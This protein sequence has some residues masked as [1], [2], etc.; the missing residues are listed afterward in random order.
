MALKAVLFGTGARLDA[1]TPTSRCGAAILVE[2]GGDRLVFDCG[3]RATKQLADAGYSIL[4]VDQIFFTHLHS[5][6]TVGYP[7]FVLSSWVGGLTADTPARTDV[8]VY[9]S[10]GMRHMT[11]A[12]YG[13]GGAFKTDLRG[14]ADAD[15]APREF[16]IHRHRATTLEW[17]AV[18]VTEITELIVRRVFFTHLHADHAVDYP[19][20]A[21][22]PWASGRAGA[23]C[24]YGPEGTA[25]M[26]R[27]L[28][29]DGGAYEADIRARIE[30]SRMRKGAKGLA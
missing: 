18:S 14:M 1:A 12:L 3:R 2:A 10:A 21:L 20:V 24:V 27:R 4:E 25:H 23:V 17:P 13:R 16:M 30:A 6:H 8:R 15:L 11:D 5:R 19:D 26:T 7:D 28:F 29:G 9:G 22:S